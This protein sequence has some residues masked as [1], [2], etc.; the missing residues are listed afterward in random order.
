MPCYKN[1][2]T[3]DVQFIGICLAN[4]GAYYTCVEAF[5]HTFNA[6]LRVRIM[7]E[8]QLYMGNYVIY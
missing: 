2:E 7:D 8:S 6:I 5:S 1:N 3:G 4:K